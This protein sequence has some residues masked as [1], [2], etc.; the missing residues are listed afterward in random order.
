LNGVFSAGYVVGT[1]LGGKLYKTYE[2]YYI[3]F[4]LSIG[5]GLVGIL[6]GILIK[7]SV[8]PNPLEDQAPMI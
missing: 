8:R 4:G 5:F 3:N 1:S 2:N 7:E 6:A